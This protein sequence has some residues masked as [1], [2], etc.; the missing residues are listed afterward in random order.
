M[1]V[2]VTDFFLLLLMIC[3]GYAA[4]YNIKRGFMI[5]FLICSDHLNCLRSV[6]TI[7]ITTENGQNILKIIFIKK[8]LTESSYFSLLWCILCT[9]TLE[10]ASLS[11]NINNKARVS[12]LSPFLWLWYQKFQVLVLVDNK[13]YFKIQGNPLTVA[14]HSS[15]SI[16]Q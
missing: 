9:A 14:K 6:G 4:N 13:T 15:Y 11:K 16:I 12:R 2:L 1:G 7:V 3:F 5:I 10:I 8:I